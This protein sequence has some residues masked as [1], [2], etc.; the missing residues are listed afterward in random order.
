M[1][2]V[3]A[4]DLLGFVGGMACLL[5]AKLLSVSVKYIMMTSSAKIRGNLP[6]SASLLFPEDS[7]SRLR[8]SR[9]SDSDTLNFSEARWKCLAGKLMTNSRRIHVEM[10]L[11]RCFGH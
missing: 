6:Q 7:G 10:N 3:W 11:G 8:R 1:F 4:V 2:S 5:D 9:H